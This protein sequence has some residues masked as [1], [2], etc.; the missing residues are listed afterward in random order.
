[1]EV[2]GTTLETIIVFWLWGS[3]WDKWTIPFKAVTPILH[4]LFSCAQAW[5][6]WVFWN[7]SR[8]EG[9]KARKILSAL[10]QEEGNSK[11]QDLE[12]A[13]EDSQIV[14][15]R[16]VVTSDMRK[17]SAKDAPTVNVVEI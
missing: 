5:G 17:T 8:K 7:L 2:A 9:Q 4:L 6:A 12:T 1:M 11:G 15:R 16:S 3:L 13:P 14:R 10:Q